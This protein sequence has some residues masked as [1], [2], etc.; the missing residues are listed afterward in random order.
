M[1]DPLTAEERAAFSSLDRKLAYS[2]EFKPAFS[3]AEIKSLRDA[4]ERLAQENA[5]IVA[6]RDA[7]FAQV[8]SLRGTCLRLESHADRLAQENAELS[9]SRNGWRADAQREARNNADKARE[10]AA[11]TDNARLWH[12]LATGWRASHTV[13]AQETAR[14]Q[15]EGRKAEA[16]AARYKAMLEQLE[17]T[18]DGQCPLCGVTA[19]HHSKKGCSLADALA[20]EP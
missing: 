8:Q 17:W 11:L 13:L 15:E 9:R 2:G 20:E 10:I 4:C 5:R 6:E 16:N 7:H 1:T 18:D 14:L 3:P 12:N 19:P